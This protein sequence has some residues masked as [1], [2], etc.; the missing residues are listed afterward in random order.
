MLLLFFK[1]FPEIGKNKRNA[2]K[3]PFSANP[4]DGTRYTPPKNNATK[5]GWNCNMA[6]TNYDRP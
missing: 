2:K 3:T 6:A 1:E 4:P 5:I